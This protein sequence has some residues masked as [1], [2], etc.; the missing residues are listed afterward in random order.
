MYNILRIFLY[1]QNFMKGNCIR[2][3]F[4]N[5]WEPKENCQ[6]V[7]SWAGSLNHSTAT[8]IWEPI[9]KLAHLRAIFKR[10][11]A[12]AREP[13]LSLDLIFYYKK[14][15]KQG[16]HGFQMKITYNFWRSKLLSVVIS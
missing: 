12:E 15:M 10:N 9:M 11:L 6:F 3:V 13:I 5:C 14:I 7:Q 2:V 16:F 8:A 4:V 1:L